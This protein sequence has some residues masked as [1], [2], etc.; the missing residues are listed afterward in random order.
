MI[1]GHTPD[2]HDDRP[3]GRASGHRCHNLGVAP[4]RGS[5]GRTVECDCATTLGRA[6]VV[7]YDLYR[8]TDGAVDRSR[9]GDRWRRLGAAST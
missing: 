9:V 5:R 1:A 8:R 4:A 2:G 7:A 6:E 3:R